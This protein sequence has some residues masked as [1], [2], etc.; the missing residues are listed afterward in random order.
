MHELEWWLRHQTPADGLRFTKKVTDQYVACSRVTL[1]NLV[2]AERVPPDRIALCH[3][4]I[5]VDEAALARARSARQQTRRRLGIPPDARVVGGVG[6]MDWRKGPDLFVQLA[7]LV[8]RRIPAN[9]VYFV[10]VGGGTSGPTPGGL[11]L[12]AAR[13]G[14]ADRI[15]LTG[16]SDRPAELIAAMDVFSLTSREDPFPLV[17]LEAAA[18][19]LP[20]VCFAQAGGAPEFALP[21]AGHIVTYLDVAEMA[22]AVVHLLE[23]DGERLHMG[24]VAAAR[25]RERHTVEQAGPILTSVIERCLQRTR[26]SSG[27][28]VSARLASCPPDLRR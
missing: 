23:R 15:K 5:E 7:G 8:S 22:D 1:S 2:E 11:L 4:F 13:L 6:T 9:D 18:A 17:M 26:G 28:Q 24:Q 19:G 16:P 10:W 20:L 25:V 12:E 27:K 3:S 14:L 21:D